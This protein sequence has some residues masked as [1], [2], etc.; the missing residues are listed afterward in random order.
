VWVLASFAWHDFWRD[1]IAGALNESDRR[2]RE[3]WRDIAD[4]G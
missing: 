3:Y 1:R 4:P 2:Y